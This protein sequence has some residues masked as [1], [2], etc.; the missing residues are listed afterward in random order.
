MDN[1]A[2]SVFAQAQAGVCHHGGNL[3]LDGNAVPCQYHGGRHQHTEHIGAGIRQDGNADGHL[4]EAGGYGGQATF[5]NAEN[6]ADGSEDMADNGGDACAVEGGGENAENY[7][8]TAHQPDIE[9]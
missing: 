7:H 1:A 3:R 9:Q 8:K 6:R 2:D 4:P 5:A